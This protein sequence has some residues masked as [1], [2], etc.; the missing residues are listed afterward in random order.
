MW[1]IWMDVW[2]EI[3]SWIPYGASGR[4]FAWKLQKG[5]PLGLS[6]GVLVDK[7]EGGV[8]GEADRV[9][10]GASVKGV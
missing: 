3:V 8:I 6:E 2:L 5:I 10:L 4:D 1:G 9:K 7:W